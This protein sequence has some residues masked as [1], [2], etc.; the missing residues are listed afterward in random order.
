MACQRPS[1]GMSTPT[2]LHNKLLSVTNHA[3]HPNGTHFF[4]NFIVKVMQQYRPMPLARDEVP[5]TSSISN[6]ASPH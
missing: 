4:S 3:L 2:P 6:H 5:F 1:N